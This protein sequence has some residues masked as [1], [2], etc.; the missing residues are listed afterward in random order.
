MIRLKVTKKQEFTISLL[1]NFIKNHNEGQVV[2]PAFSDE[3]Y[4]HEPVTKFYSNPA[5]CIYLQ[6]VRPVIFI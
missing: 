1:D 3:E 6:S 5:S 2:P 4:F